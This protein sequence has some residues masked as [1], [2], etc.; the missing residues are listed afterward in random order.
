M[1]ATDWWDLL[2]A[3]CFNF[4][5]LSLLLWGTFATVILKTVHKAQMC[6]T[7]WGI[8]N[9]TKSSRIPKLRDAY[10][11]SRAKSIFLTE[12]FPKP[13][14]PTGFLDALLSCTRL[15]GSVSVCVWVCVCVWRVKRARR[16]IKCESFNAE[17]KVRL[18]Q[19]WTLFLLLYRTGVF[20][21]GLVM[22]FSFVWSIFN[23]N[24]C[25]SVCVRQ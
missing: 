15:G 23:V 12:S 2:V 7:R 22:H 1:T 21:T 13:K 18:N 14:P 9:Q 20:I 8:S 24:A 6:G 3:L 17:Y 11:N 25:R 10:T 5:L 16:G 19:S 4:P